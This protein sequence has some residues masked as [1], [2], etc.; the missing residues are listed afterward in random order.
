MYVHARVS[1]QLIRDQLILMEGFL[2]EPYKDWGYVRIKSS[3]KYSLFSVLRIVYR[4]LLR[5]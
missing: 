4:V 5:Q 3:I 1:R 2:S